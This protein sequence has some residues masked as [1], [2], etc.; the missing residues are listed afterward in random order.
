MNIVVRADSGIEIGTGHVMRCL[1]LAKALRDQGHSLIFICKEH[2]GNISSV[3]EKEGFRVFFLPLNE[4][5]NDGLEH[6]KWLGGAQRA[7]AEETIAVSEQ[8]FSSAIDLLIVDHYGI[9]TKWHSI[10][11]AHSLESRIFVIDDLADRAHSCDYLLDQTFM[12][13]ESDYSQLVP[14]RCQLLLG[15]QFTL[16]R[17]E[18]TDNR[19]CAKEVRNLGINEQAKRVLVM[20]GGTDHLNVTEKV[21]R[22]IQDEQ[23]VERITVV[24]GSTAP[25]RTSIERTFGSDSRFALLSGVSNVAELMLAHDVC[26]GAAGTASWERCAMGLPSISVAFANNQRKILSILNKFG[27]VYVFEAAEQPKSIIEKLNKVC[28]AETYGR[29]VENCFKVSD[30]FGIQRVLGVL[31][32]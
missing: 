22:A 6:S 16:L 13:Q 8:Y 28:E 2:D 5:V 24:L 12:R 14:N 19:A 3:I 29:M 1:T 17:A 26:F 25:H 32:Q 31:A 23:T 10:V 15:A 11:K 4:Y 18:F 20:L 27:A 30:G 21:L 9:D 7:D